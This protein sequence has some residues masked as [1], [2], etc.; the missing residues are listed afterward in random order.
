MAHKCPDFIQLVVQGG[1]LTLISS[2]AS[3]EL[4]LHMHAYPHTHTHSFREEALR[5]EITHIQ[6]INFNSLG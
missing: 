4:S 2:D 3:S 1:I 5:E 6:A